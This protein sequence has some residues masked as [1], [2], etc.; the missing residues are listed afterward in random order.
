MKLEEVRAFFAARGLP[1]DWQTDLARPAR[2]PL[3]LRPPPGVTLTLA[4]VEVAIVVP[5]VHLG[6]GRDAFVGDAP[7]RITRFEAFLDVLAAMRAS[8]TELDVVQVGDWYDFF[9]APSV[10]KANA[11]ANIEK[12]YPGIV[13]RAAALGMKHCIGNHDS[14][15]VRPEIRKGLDVEIVRTVGDAHRVLCLHG[16]DTQILTSIAKQGAL[17]SIVLNLLTLFATAHPIGGALAGFIQ[18]LADKSS[19]DPWSNKKD[20]LPWP[21]AKVPGPSN[22]SAPWVA[23]ASAV[24]IGGAVAGLELCLGVKFQLALVGHSHRPGISWCP[25]SGSRRLPLVDVGSWTYGRA[26]FAVVC[27][28]GLGLA[29]LSV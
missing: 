17:D 5:D 26:E 20:S 13:K 2:S 24:D 27:A 28:E 9:R 14:V 18:K 10:T 7:N 12:S 29:K 19:A 25:V 6:W 21:V 11:K 4:P 23:R 8:G 16:D 3:L 15:F 1:F 22:W